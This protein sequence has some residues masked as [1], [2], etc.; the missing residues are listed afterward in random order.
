MQGWISIHRK[1]L[2]NPVV[3]KDADYLSVWIY[4]LLNATHKSIP[5]MFRGTKIILQEGQLITGRKAISDKLKVSE[6][7]VQ[8]ILKAFEN[9]QQIEQQSSNKN[10]LISITNWHLYQDTEQRIEQP[11]N[12]ERTT[13]EQPVNTNNNV[14]NVIM[15]QCNKRIFI[16]PTLEEVSA[17]CAE[18]HNSVDP[19]RFIDFYDSK[20]WMVGR[21]KMK[22]WKAAVRTW[23]R[24]SE[25]KTQ[26]QEEKKEVI[27][28][29]GWRSSFDV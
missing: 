24:R 15:K 11:V 2:D 27:Y 4:L 3:C 13:D 21:N 14:N 5:A 29:N 1:I 10:R 22:D 9:E 12:N 28:R 6:S 25:Q 23:E 20:G 19:D 16:P 18:R 7:K 26:E 17:Y 8:R